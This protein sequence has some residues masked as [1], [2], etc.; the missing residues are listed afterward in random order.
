MSIKEENDRY[1]SLPRFRDQKPWIG[2]ASSS[3][4]LQIRYPAHMDGEEINNEEMAQMETMDLPNGYTFGGWGHKS[5]VCEKQTRGYKQT[6]Y[7]K[8]C[9]I[10]LNS[11]DTM[12]SHVQ[13]VKHLKKV[14]DEQR[15]GRDCKEVV[16]PIRN[17][18]PTTKKMPVRLATKIGESSI[19]VVGLDFLKEFIAVSDPEMEPHY[20]CSLCDSQGQAN[21]MFSHLMGQRHRQ[22]FVNKL[23]GDDHASAIK[24]SQA[25]LLRYANKYNENRPGFEERIITITSDEEYPWPSGKEP[26]D[27]LNG[28]NGI[29]P[30]GARCNY[31]RKPFKSEHSSG[32]LS[33]DR[34]PVILIKPK[35]DYLWKAVA[36]KNKSDALKMCALAKRT[37]QQLMEYKGL[38]FKQHEKSSV[39]CLLKLMSLK[40]EMKVKPSSST[41]NWGSNNTQHRIKDEP[42]EMELNTK[43]RYV[44]SHSAELNKD[45]RRQNM[46]EY[47]RKTCPEESFNPLDSS[48][49]KRRRIDEQYEDD[50]RSGK[51]YNSRSSYREDSNHWRSDRALHRKW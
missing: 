36:P 22:E 38:K 44:S 31:G 6:F 10:E 12:I 41:S 42:V 35:F 11:N 21:C 25:D 33:Q 50:W 19:P 20:E 30:D 24:L 23:K 17:P 43:S 1:N 28:G 37:F 48:N 5:R 13:G 2:P 27:P 29:I 51:D 7:C 8:L 15:R 47:S 14:T 40:I 32:P 18:E 49:N 16:I 34:K 46:Q 3:G 4:S 39:E 9:M 45:Y 26:W